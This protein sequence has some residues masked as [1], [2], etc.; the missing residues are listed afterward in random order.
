[1]QEAEHRLEEAE[2]RAGRAHEQ[3]HLKEG[4]VD[5]LRRRLA[6][7]KAE[8]RQGQEDVARLR[9]E[10]EAA[11]ADLLAQAQARQ[12]DAQTAQGRA[13]DLEG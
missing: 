10:L 9:R 8:A 1:V 6:T 12:R 13:A 7:A 4:E 2:T 3:L 11:G 5:G